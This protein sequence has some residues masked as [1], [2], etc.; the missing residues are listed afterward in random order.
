MEPATTMKRISASVPDRVFDQLNELAD[1]EGRSFSN[2][3]SYLLEQCIDARYEMNQA[4]GR[5][6][7]PIYHPQ[8]SGTVNE[9]FNQLD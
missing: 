6:S 9:P 5:T 3:V 4:Q 1:I 2:L 7:K 8:G